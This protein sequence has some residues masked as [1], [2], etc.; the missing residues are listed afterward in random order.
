MICHLPRTIRRSIS[1]NVTLLRLLRRFWSFVDC[2]HPGIRAVLAAFK[3][4]RGFANSFSDV[5]LRLCA[6]APGLLYA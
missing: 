3:N 5:L 1:V 6:C 4:H 2:R